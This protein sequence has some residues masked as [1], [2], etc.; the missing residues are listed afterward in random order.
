MNTRMHMGDEVEVNR[1]VNE[2]A[3]DTMNIYKKL[4]KIN[5]SRRKKKRKSCN[6]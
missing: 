3:I 1:K 4:I 6:L 5:F 2:Y